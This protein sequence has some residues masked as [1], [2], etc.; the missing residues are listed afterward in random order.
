[1]EQIFLGCTS[2]SIV[3]RIFSISL[4]HLSIFRNQWPDFSAKW[5][6]LQTIFGAGGKGSKLTFISF[7][8]KSGRKIGN[9]MPIRANIKIDGAF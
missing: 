9:L 4:C 2:I 3:S 5:T 1:M 7:V 6:D 8:Y